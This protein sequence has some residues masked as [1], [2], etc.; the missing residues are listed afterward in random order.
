MAFP[1]TPVNGQQATVNNIVYTFS[2]TDNTW[3]R[4]STGFVNLGAS[5]NISAAGNIY[6]NYIVGN[7]SGTV[8]SAQTV[9]NNAQPNITSVGTLTSLTASGLISTTG[10]VVGNYIL[11]N[12]SQLVNVVAN[13]IN[14]TFNGSANTFYLDFVAQNGANNQAVWNSPF[15]T[16]VPTTG[17]LGASALT[18]TGNV[19]G[20]N[21]LTAGLMSS[22]GNAI[23][24]NVLTGGQ[25]SATGN[26]TG[27]YHIGNGAT[28][29]SIT[30]ANVTGTVANATFATS[31][32]SAVGTAAT[33]TTNAQPN[34][35]STGT[36]TSLTASG[37]ISTTGN[38]VGNY[39]LG[40]GALLT[41]V[42]TSVANINLGNSNVTVTS[43]GGNVTV[44]VGGIANVAVFATTGEYV[45]GVLSASGNVIGGNI[46]TAGLISATST[47]T[48]AA[49]IISG[50]ITTAGLITATGNV[51]G[52]NILTSGLISA[53]GNA[54]VGNISAT[55][56]T[57]TTVSVTGNVT[58]NY[59]VGNGSALTGISSGNS[60]I[61]ITVTTISANYTIASGQN[62]LSV[63]PVTI[64]NNVQ[65]S[66]TPGQRWIIL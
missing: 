42:I 53:T 20:G 18:A 60:S 16:Y 33:V 45:T 56:H 34:I 24:G 19:T 55:N 62:G 38:V 2:S 44:G 66:V 10:N 65:V 27:N 51:T 13:T 5:G 12:G 43:S 32:G 63:G 15:L 7:I 21:L 14:T 49:N 59:F 40:N 25:V 30:G 57:G 6:G 52:G 22:T 1:T 26:V 58:G 48:S 37:L 8:N 31:A 50:N 11:G 46:L 36:L 39:I 23:H 4:T 64:G 47:I 3:T 35:T 9:T 61:N 54:T 17:L 41:G 29:S 28:L